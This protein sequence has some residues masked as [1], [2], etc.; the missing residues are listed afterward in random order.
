MRFENMAQAMDSQPESRLGHTK[1]ERSYPSAAIAHTAIE[2]G[3]RRSLPCRYDF[4]GDAN[5][6]NSGHRFRLVQIPAGAGEG[7]SWDKCEINFTLVIVRG[8]PEAKA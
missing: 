1:N 4:Q 2:S 7:N 5:S 8:F 6:Q 3:L